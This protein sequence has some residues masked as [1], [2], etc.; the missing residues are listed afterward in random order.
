MDALTPDNHEQCL[1]SIIKHWAEARIDGPMQALA[2]YDDAAKHLITIGGFLQGGLIAVYSVLERQGRVFQNGWQIAIV[3]LFEL[4]LIFFISLAA[5][6]CTLQ[7]EMQAKSIS[8]LLTK[9]SG[10]GSQRAI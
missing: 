9:P 7:P 2:R 5:L 8:Y 4:S 3:V 1:K 10:S 6:A